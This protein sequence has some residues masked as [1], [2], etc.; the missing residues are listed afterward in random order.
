MLLLARYF[1]FNKKVLIKAEKYLQVSA[2]GFIPKFIETLEKR[3]TTYL[4]ES[5]KQIG[6]LIMENSASLFTKQM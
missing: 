1:N 5:L 3:D 2:S 6:D 4:E